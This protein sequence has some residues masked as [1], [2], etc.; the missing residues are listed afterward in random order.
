MLLALSGKQGVGKDTCA[1]MFVELGFSSIAYADPMKRKF[2]E[3]TGLPIDVYDDFKRSSL[4]YKE[5]SMNGRDICVGIGMLMRE[6]SPNLFT[7]TVQAFIDEKS[8]TV[9][10]DMRFQNELDHMKK[11]NATIIKIV[12]PGIDEIKHISEELSDR[13]DYYDELIINDGT[14]GQLKQKVRTIYETHK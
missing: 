5:N 3:I 10:T 12:R 14:I 9:V 13:N 4:S 7:D 8:N 2:A 11:N 6:L 1:E